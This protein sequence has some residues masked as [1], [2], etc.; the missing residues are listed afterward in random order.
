[1]NDNLS[2]VLA[3]V[4]LALALWLFVKSIGVPLQSWRRGLVT[5]MDHEAGVKYKRGK[6]VELLGAGR[7]STWPRDI[8]I[9]RLD[10]REA[11][12]SVPGQEMLT[13]DNMTLRVSGLLRY[14][15]TDP[16]LYVRASASPIARLYE[17]TQIA[18]RKRV[19]ASTLDAL[20]A[21]RTALDDG[22]AEELNAQAQAYGMSIAGVSVLDLTL[23]GPAKQAFADLWKAQKEGLAALERARG[24]QAALRAL[25]NAARMLKGNPELMNLRVLAALQG[26]SGKSA[27]SVILGG[28]PGLVP[29]TSDPSATDAEP[30][31]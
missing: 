25:S 16:A 24:E 17:T 20:L 18:I 3:L 14:A 29:I 26:Q 28:A 4:L 19:A 2:S 22:L 12:L 23:A 30:A 27:P 1:M 31:P 21:D 8:A 13:A 9:T 10:L 5:L 15:I 11:S 6:F 7:Y